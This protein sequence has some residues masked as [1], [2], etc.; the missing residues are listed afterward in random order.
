MRKLKEDISR[1]IGLAFARRDGSNTNRV[2]IR[3]IRGG[4]RSALS[5]CRKGTSPSLPDRQSLGE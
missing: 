5:R 1:E 4:K 2:G 3:Q